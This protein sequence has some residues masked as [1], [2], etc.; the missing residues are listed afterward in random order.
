METE[1]ERQIKA[2]DKRH[3]RNKAEP[4]ACPVCGSPMQNTD[5]ET[6]NEKG[7]CSA[8]STALDTEED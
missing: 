5:R 7:M 2:L 8:C 3:D 1:K 6:F 4:I